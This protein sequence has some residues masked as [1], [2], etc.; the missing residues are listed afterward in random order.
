[1][2]ASEVYVDL[3]EALQGEW[4]GAGLDALDE[5]RRHVVSIANWTGID[6]VTVARV[7]GCLDGWNG[8][9]R[10]CRVCGCTDDRACEG[11]CAWVADDLCSA[12]EDF[13][14]HNPGPEVLIDVS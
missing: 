3:D 5:I 6:Q 10:H 7:L 14:R 9:V 13:D 2:S 1:M 11:G 4:A 8:V 12:C